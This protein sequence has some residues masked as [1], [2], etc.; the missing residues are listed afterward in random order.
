MMAIPFRDQVYAL[1]EAGEHYNIAFP[2]RHVETFA[3]QSDIPYYDLLPPLRQYARD[4]QAVLYTPSD[5]HFNELGHRVTGELI[6]LFLAREFGLASI[7]SDAI[8]D[9]CLTHRQLI[10]DIGVK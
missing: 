10:S 1:H 3:E 8:E 9:R 7:S 4:C 2:Q 5:S 6:T